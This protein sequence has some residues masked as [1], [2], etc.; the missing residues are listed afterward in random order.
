[1]PINDDPSTSGPAKPPENAAAKP[2]R[3]EYDP[4]WKRILEVLLEPAL[5]LFLPQAW[6]DIDWTRPPVSVEK[7][8]QKLL[9]RSQSRHRWADKVWKTWRRNGDES[10]VYLHA[11]IQGDPDQTLPKRMFTSSYRIFDRYEV[12]VASL[13]ILTDDNPGWDPEDAYGW[14]LW[15]SQMGLRFPCVRLR[16]YTEGELEVLALDNPW[17]VVIKAHLATKR[18]RKQPQRRYEAK[19]EVFLELLERGYEPQ[20]VHAVADFIDWV[21]KLPEELN[22][23]LLVEL[24]E[25]ETENMQ[26]INSYSRFVLKRER[27]EGHEEGHEEG[28]RLGRAEMLKRLAAHRFGELPARVSERI[29]GADIDT[30]DAWSCQLLDAER[31][32]DVFVP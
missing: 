20:V 6:A 23:R 18:T 12:P 11:E 8:L 17:A 13:A 21:M 10:L 26:Y 27:R 28:T 32:D 9:P 31:L 22:D 3:D 7:D 1:M 2:E 24:E 25:T 15:G 29:E 16:E 19:R 30:L 4:P 5:K 14:E